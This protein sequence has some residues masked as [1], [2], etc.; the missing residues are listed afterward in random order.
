M[1]HSK[2]PNGHSVN[3]SNSERE[4]KKKKKNKQEMERLAAEK[5]QKA[6]IPPSEMFRGDEKYSKYDDEGVPTH[7]KGGEPLSK[8]AR[9]KLLKMHGAQKKKYE[10]AMAAQ[11]AL[12]GNDDVSKQ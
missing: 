7:D 1:V 6:L 10:K 5:A 8:S 3:K 12:Q 4:R 9:K 11:T 2:S